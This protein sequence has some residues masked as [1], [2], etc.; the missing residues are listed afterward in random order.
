MVCGKHSPLSDLRYSYQHFVA[1]TLPNL[2]LAMH[3]FP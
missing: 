3:M 1:E 2:S